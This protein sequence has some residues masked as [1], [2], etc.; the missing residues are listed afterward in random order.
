MAA[1]L[2]WQ[3]S[4]GPTVSSRYPIDG[5]DC[6]SSID[7]ASCRY[8]ACQMPV[9]TSSRWIERLATLGRSDVLGRCLGLFRTENR[10]V[11]VTQPLE[12]I[13]D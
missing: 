10:A 3:G 12:R 5:R 1:F 2:D 8:N 4:L 6:P 9:E 11:S 7:M 13:T